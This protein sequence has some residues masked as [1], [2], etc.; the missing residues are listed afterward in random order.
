[1]GAEGTV[2]RA[3]WHHTDVAVKEMHPQTSSSMTRLATRMRYVCLGGSAL[4]QGWQ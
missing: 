1:M 4:P 3:K 2:W